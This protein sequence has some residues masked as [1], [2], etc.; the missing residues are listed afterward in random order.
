MK[1]KQTARVVAGFALVSALLFRPEA[2]TATFPGENGM[3]AVEVESGPFSDQIVILN[4]DGS[5]GHYFPFF[6]DV[7]HGDPNWSPPSLRERSLVAPFTALN[8]PRGTVSTRYL[9]R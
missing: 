3:L 5:F 2:A 4:P 8:E 6:Q 7:H 1:W 9:A